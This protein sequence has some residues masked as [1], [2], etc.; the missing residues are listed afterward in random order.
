MVGCVMGVCTPPGCIKGD[1]TP[2][3]WGVP[4]KKKKKRKKE[5]RKKS[6]CEKK[7]YI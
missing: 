1:D 2:H 4:Y 5:K 3:G 6:L 7:I